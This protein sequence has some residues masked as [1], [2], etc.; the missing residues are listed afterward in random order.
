MPDS[1]S[2]HVL[3]PRAPPGLSETWGAFLIG[4]TISV[5][6][7]VFSLILGYKYF[8][9][10]PTDTRFLRC[11]VIA[12][13]P[14]DVFQT[15]TNVYTCPHVNW[16]YTSYWHLVTNHANPESLIL[17]NWSFIAF[18]PASIVTIVLCQSFYAHRVFRLGGLYRWFALLAVIGMGATLGL[19]IALTVE[20]V[21]L[22][23]L[24]AFRPITWMVTSIY[25]TIMYT[26]VILTCALVFMLW[27]RRSGRKEID[28]VIAGIIAYTISSGPAVRLEIIDPWVRTAHWVYQYGN[29]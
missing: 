8:R 22:P 2:L 13:L 19:D 21:I 9:L 17:E 25:G 1:T 11:I 29:H 16:R 6:L 7:N 15:I 5:F 12:V 10:Y 18:G 14:L 27:R 24:L 4:T 23:N 26:D 3:F 28:T 20:S